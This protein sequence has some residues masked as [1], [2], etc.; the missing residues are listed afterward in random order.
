MQHGSVHAVTHRHV[1]LA[2]WGLANEVHSSGCWRARWN[3]SNLD[4]EP[5]R[6]CLASAHTHPTLS[7][8]WGVIDWE[9]D[10]APFSQVVGRQQDTHHLTAASAK[11]W[12][13][14]FWHLCVWTNI[15]EKWK[16]PYVS[17]STQIIYFRWGLPQC[18]WQLSLLLE[19]CIIRSFCLLSKSAK[20]ARLHGW[21]RENHWTHGFCWEEGGFW[22]SSFLEPHSTLW[23]FIRHLRF[24]FFFLKCKN[25]WAHIISTQLGDLLF[26]RM[27]CRYLPHARQR[28]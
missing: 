6:V 28:L 15:T 4:A 27:R 14:S 8:A 19:S 23:Y 9:A 7:A 13:H 22:C 20:T 26:L 11:V 25:I 1:S 18:C 3:V 12:G 17:I 10:Y 5:A 24:F 21:G 2:S 16:D